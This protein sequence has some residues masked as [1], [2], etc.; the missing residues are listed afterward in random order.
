MKFLLASLMTI[1][2]A[3]STISNAADREFADVYAECGIGAAIFN[4]SGSNS[5]SA[6]IL[7]IVSNLTWDWGTT[8][9]LSNASSEENCQGSSVSTAAFLYHSYDQIETDLAQGGGDHLDALLNVV[10]CSVPRENVVSSLRAALTATAASGEATTHD[11][12]GS[13]YNTLTGICTV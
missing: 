1:G 10:S 2:L 4:S 8:A 13:I 3:F 9:H 11:S 7:A 5:D 6:R 12:A